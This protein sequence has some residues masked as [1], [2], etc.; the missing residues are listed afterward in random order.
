MTAMPSKRTRGDRAIDWIEEYCRVPSGPGKGQ[1]V[2]LGIEDLITVRAIYDAPSSECHRV[3]GH[4]AAYLALIHTCGLEAPGSSP[5]PAELVTDI[6]SVWNAADSPDLR[7]VLKREGEA[8]ICP[9]L[10]TR[11]A[12]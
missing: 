5:P 11:W 4:L 10:G 3:A 7:R 2:V 8:I 1:H 6:F 9:A 12:A